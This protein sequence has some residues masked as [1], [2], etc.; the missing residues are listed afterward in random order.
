[1]YCT[2]VLP[3]VAA[4]DP[5]AAACA[6]TRKAA[7][8]WDASDVDSET[9]CEESAGLYL[10]IVLR[11]GRTTAHERKTRSDA[12]IQWKRCW[13]EALRSKGGNS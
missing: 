1:M 9:V 5:G 7:E 13:N 10:R 4:A 2:F 11:Y 12:R 3:V 8:R 6:A